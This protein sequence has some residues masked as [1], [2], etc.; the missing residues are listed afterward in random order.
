MFIAPLCFQFG[1]EFFFYGTKLFFTNAKTSLCKRR[2]IRKVGLIIL[3]YQFRPILKP[4]TV[5][6]VT[7]TRKMS[8]DFKGSVVIYSVLGCPHCMRA[9]KLLSENNVPYTDV[10]L[11][12]FPQ[13]KEEVMQRSGMK[14]VPQVFFN[15]KLIG[16]NDA[17]QKLVR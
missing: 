12:L 11:D 14:T 5:N 17:L 3:G 15:A 6:C 7:E 13:I 8:A 10:R 4:L 16:G 2:Q 1:K 9:K